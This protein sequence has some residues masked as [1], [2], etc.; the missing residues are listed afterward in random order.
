MLRFH[1]LGCVLKQ[2]RKLVHD[3][4]R[5]DRHSQALELTNDPPVLALVVRDNTLP[6]PAY[7]AK[8]VIVSET[9]VCITDMGG[10]PPLFHAIIWQV[11]LQ[12][13]RGDVQF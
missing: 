8:D 7:G 13:G 6:G 11:T 1:K 2:L 3:V 10:F 4:A 9:S 5:F 12:N